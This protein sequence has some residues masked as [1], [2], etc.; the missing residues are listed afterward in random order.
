MV[1]NLTQAKQQLWLWQKKRVKKSV[2]NLQRLL[3]SPG[4][5]YV[6]VTSVQMASGFSKIKDPRINLIVR[7]KSM[8]Y[9]ILEKCSAINKKNFNKLVTK[10]QVLL[11]ASFGSGR[12]VLIL[13]REAVK[14]EKKD[15]AISIFL[16][17]YQINWSRE[18]L[19]GG[20]VG[21]RRSITLMIEMKINIRN[22]D[23]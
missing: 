8:Q 2:Q 17:C 9:L 5:K 12:R 4:Q 15:L 22:I 20:W 7:L 19:R 1:P 13:F 18:V 6:L 21:G 23:K 10:I 14:V 11:F 16:I 3:Q